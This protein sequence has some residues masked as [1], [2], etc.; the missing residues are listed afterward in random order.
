MASRQTTPA[1][2]D[3]GQQ[4]AE[5]PGSRGH[6]Y[7]RSHHHPGD[8][9]QH[10]PR[11]FASSLRQHRARRDVLRRR[12]DVHGLKNVTTIVT[13]KVA[14]TAHATANGCCRFQPARPSSLPPRRK[15]PMDPANSARPSNPFT[16]RTTTRMWWPTI[17]RPR[18][19]VHA[20]RQ[21][22]ANAHQSRQRRGCDQLQNIPRGCED[23]HAAIVAAYDTEA[24][25]IRLTQRDRVRI[26]SDD[27]ESMRCCDRDYPRIHHDP[28]VAAGTTIRGWW[29]TA[30]RQ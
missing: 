5:L 20:V 30:A 13:G 2:G 1:M 6:P 28:V 4:P 25:T 23:D 3:T 8:A 12:A 11:P 10:A 26:R 29:S 16:H 22:A 15:H 19:R 14:F 18:A 21:L 24:G 7:R 9:Q 27:A 17:A